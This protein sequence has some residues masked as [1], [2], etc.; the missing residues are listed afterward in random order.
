MQPKQPNSSIATILETRIICQQP[1]SYIG[2]PTV[3]QGPDGELHAVFSGRRD[4]HVCPFGANYLI[5]STDQGQSWS[6]PQL[7][8]DTPIDDRDAGL[9]IAGDGTLVISWF[10][11]HYP[12]EQYQGQYGKW[13]QRGFPVRPWE[14][15]RE[16]IAKVDESAISEWTQHPM[17]DEEGTPQRWL[18]F[19]TRRS[20]DGGRTWDTPTPS[21]VSAPHGP[22]LLPDGR[23]AYVGTTG[24]DGPLEKRV[25]R[26]VVSSD[27]GRTWQ[28]LATL[29]PLGPKDPP[30]NL[31]EPHLLVTS[32]GKWLIQAR[33]Q[34]AVEKR[35]LW[36]S[37]SLDH[38]RTWSGWKPTSLQGFPPHLMELKDGRLLV[39]YSIRRTS[40]PGQRAAVSSDDGQT[41][42]DAQEV[43]LTESESSDLGYPSTVQLPNGQLLSLYYQRPK[44]DEK[45]CLMMTR[46]QLG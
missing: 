1:Q 3:A 36:Q 8:N 41:W 19:W 18:G 16:A 6:E 26:I 32:S 35:F 33:Y 30:A 31:C 28:P 22:S 12:I 24:D 17:R 4:T 23:L 9:C 38:G 15:W 34:G 37:E 46:W 10:T 44:V 29:D 39:T 21:P 7:V 13:S 20:S 5:S 43:I 42:Q 40:R 45:P 27:L 14:E 11:S 2:W 25:L